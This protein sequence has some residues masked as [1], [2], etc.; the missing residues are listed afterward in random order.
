MSIWSMGVLGTPGSDY[1]K[2]FAGGLPA[3]GISTFTNTG[4]TGWSNP[5]TSY[6]FADSGDGF[7]CICACHNLDGTPQVWGVSM[8]SEDDTLYTQLGAGAIEPFAQQSGTYGFG[9]V[10][11]IVAAISPVAGRIQLFAAAASGDGTTERLITCW[12][13]APDDQSW[14]KWY[15]MSPPG[16]LLPRLPDPGDPS[17]AAPWY[18]PIAA[19]NIYDGRVQLWAIRPDDENAMTGKLTTCWKTANAK[20]APWTEWVDTPLSDIGALSPSSVAAAVDEAGHAQVFVADGGGAWFGAL[21]FPPTDP[22]QAPTNRFVDAT[23]QWVPLS[24]FATV[25]DELLNLAWMYGLTSFSDGSG[26]QLFA[27][28]SIGGGFP[29]SLLASADG[30]AFDTWVTLPQ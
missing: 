23:Y 18:T 10:D 16:G 2:L 21:Q 26:I 30:P 6:G 12:Q 15:D 4:I 9:R 1:Y 5:V 20:N 25:D 17:S 7:S 28:G 29:P 14:T 8:S 11:A 3:G 27:V 13:D 19:H 24:P 22:V